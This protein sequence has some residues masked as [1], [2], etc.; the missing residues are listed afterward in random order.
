MKHILRLFVFITILL[1]GMNVHASID[2]ESELKRL[3]ESLESPNLKTKLW[4]VRRLAR[5]PA[6]I[7]GPILLEEFKKPIT[8]NT[9]I[10]RCAIVYC[11]GQMEYT[12]S[13]PQLVELLKMDLSSY[14]WTEP[15]VFKEELKGFRRGKDSSAPGGPGGPG[16]RRDN[17]SALDRR[18]ELIANT[19]QKMLENYE[20]KLNWGLLHIRTMQV[21]GKFKAKEA[22]DELHKLMIATAVPLSLIAA[23]TMKLIK[24]PKSEELL[25]K[26]VWQSYWWSQLLYVMTELTSSYDKNLQYDGTEWIKKSIFQLISDELDRP[27]QTSEGLIKAL[28]IMDLLGKPK[29]E[30]YDFS[31]EVNIMK[32]FVEFTSML[33]GNDPEIMLFDYDLIIRFIRD[34]VKMKALNNIFSDILKP[35]PVIIVPTPS[36]D[37]PVEP[38][39]EVTP[40]QPSEKKE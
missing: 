4:A 6:W 18:S 39:P 8:Q 16:G 37:T 27:G 20:Q 25:L 26:G 15:E 33:K 21:I 19:R 11:F 17:P 1:N 35:S 22:S 23:D 31:S 3:K 36:H 24:D 12:V 5:H 10:V 14:G 29:C 13:I 7:S 9:L 28:N 40:K 2:L 38:K 34:E 32:E 30:I